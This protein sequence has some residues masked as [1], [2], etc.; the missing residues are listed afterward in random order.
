MKSCAALQRAGRAAAEGSSRLRGS[1]H[2]A[3][4]TAQPGSYN[5]LR[6]TLKVVEVDGKKVVTLTDPLPAP[7]AADASSRPEPPAMTRP[8]LPLSPVTNDE[9]AKARYK[10]RHPTPNHAKED[11][12]FDPLLNLHRLLKRNPYAYALASP[13]RHCPVTNTTLPVFF[14]QQFKLVAHTETGEPWWMPSHFNL[15]RGKQFQPRADPTAAM[16]GKGAYAL[17]RGELLRAMS[18]P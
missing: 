5:S 15:G 18:P 14:H 13:V 7:Q 3:A 9:I 4:G 6:R 12:A 2:G 8:S 17:A 1:S 11:G 10:Y 16:P